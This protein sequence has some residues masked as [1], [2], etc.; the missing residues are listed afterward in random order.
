MSARPRITVGV[1]VRNGE[2]FLAGALESILTQDIDGLEVVVSD[3]GSDDATPD[4]AR[5]AA[6]RD[7]RVTF[8]RVPENR[9]AAWNY[10]H[11]VDVSSGHYFKWASHD[12]VLLP[13]HLASC[14]GELEAAGPGVVLAYPQTLLVDADDRVL[15][16]YDDHCDVR[17]PESWERLRHLLRHLRLCNPVFGVMRRDVLLTTRR[18]GAFHSSD[19][20]LMAE[21]ALRG[22][23]HEVPGRRF[24]RRRLDEP[25]ARHTL[26]RQEKTAWFR[27][28]GRAPRLPMVRTRLVG[29]H[30]RS[31][32]VAP[33]PMAE[34]RRCLQVLAAEWAPRYWRTV[35]GELKAVV[36]DRFDL[37]T[38]RG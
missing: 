22:E 28:D 12:D 23:I 7:R 19:V 33:L 25:G 30:V 18:I 17:R 36:R 14:V 8:L 5:E 6:A 32:W 24:L 27:A 37:Q 29:E 2:R 21:L 10:N 38:A 4:I 13:G 20:V 35:G 3:N 26:T 31:I 15:E 1:P 16:V 9:G 11:L 34:R